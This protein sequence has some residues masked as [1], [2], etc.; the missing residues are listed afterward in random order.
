MPLLLTEH[1]IKRVLPMPDLIEA[2][3]DALADYSAARVVQPVRTVLEV[4]PAHAYFGVMPA[5]S[6]DEAGQGTMGA[7][8]V[9]VYASNHA[10]GLTSHL[11]TIILM[12]AE[13]GALT[14]LL[15]GRYITESRTAAVSAVS[16]D[17]M[18][19]PEAQ[20]LAIIGSGVQARSHLEAIRHVRDLTAV[21]VW[22]PNPEHSAQ[23]AK[24]MTVECGIPVWS[25]DAASS[26]VREADIVV[27][28]T[29]STTPV[30]TRQD[31]APGTHICAV[32]ACRPTH[33][34]MT[35]SLVT[36]ARVIVDSRAAAVLEAGDLVI[37]IG[38]GA[39][40]ER[41][42]AGEL[43]EVVL[44]QCVGRRHDD[45]ITV[46]KSLGMAVED[47]VAA[48]LAVDRAE[49]AGLGQRFTLQ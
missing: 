21:R 7:K 28:V 20:V 44:G 29:G 38:E 15:D 49:A 24:E 6:V 41:Q 18:A 36:A 4:G 11:A 37:P 17:R 22:S 1:D 43:G 9:T 2:M 26:A 13:T 40:T 42:I 5:A 45:E 30:I 31:I 34:E 32:G 23:F 33:R 16:V 19:R 48:R 3:A 35:T 12:D 10:R 46:F 25:A 39:F 47:I 27:L 8:L 14:A